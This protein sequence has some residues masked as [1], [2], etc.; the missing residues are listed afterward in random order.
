MSEINPTSDYTVQRIMDEFGISQEQAEIAYERQKVYGDPKVNHDGIA[1]AWAGILQ[2]WALHIAEM[3]PIPPHVVA[4][5]MAALKMNRMRMVYHKD[6]Y[7]DLKVYM[8]FA[9]AWQKSCTDETVV[10]GPRPS[11]NHKL[12]LVWVEDDA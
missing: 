7:D 1:Q 2:P 10:I 11:P 3:K 12:K 4:L 6:N 5:L 8:S 9:H